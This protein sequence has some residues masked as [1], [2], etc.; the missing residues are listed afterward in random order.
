MKFTRAKSALLAIA[1]IGAIGAIGAIAFG[2]SRYLDFVFTRS[3]L[4]C[5]VRRFDTALWQDSARVY[6]AE[7]V[8]RCMVDDL[9]GRLDDR[10]Q[11]RSEIVGLLGVPRPSTYF[12]EYDLVYW[13][14]P[15]RGM[16]VD[17]EWLVFR[18]DRADRVSEAR[19][20]TD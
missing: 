12:S 1:A 8:R 13:V 20:V 17:S 2:G 4:R 7:P 6:S 9:L 16:G 15:E 11:S 5:A 14:G 19:L 18:F 3:D 10:H